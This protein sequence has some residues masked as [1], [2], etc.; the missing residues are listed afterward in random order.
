LK[1]RNLLCTEYDS[2]LNP[3]KAD[4]RLFERTLLL[5][6]YHLN[7]VQS[8][9][10]SCLWNQSSETGSKACNPSSWFNVWYAAATS[11]PWVGWISKVGM[12]STLPSK[13][14]GNP[15][16]KK[17][18]SRAPHRIHRQSLNSDQGQGLSPIGPL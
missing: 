15:A 16:F 13:L 3:S 5:A 7:T 8:Q 9:S 11:I 6:M 14:T 2:Y 17:V 1:L 18:N 4:R 12:H 10:N